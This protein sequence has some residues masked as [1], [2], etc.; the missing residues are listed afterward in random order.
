[1]H[2]PRLATLLLFFLS[3]AL[4]TMGKPAVRKRRAKMA[5]FASTMESVRDASRQ[6]RQLHKLHKLLPHRKKKKKEGVLYFYSVFK[7]L[8]MS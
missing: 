8:A 1:M 5:S 3:T 7:R 4:P 2:L 6:Q